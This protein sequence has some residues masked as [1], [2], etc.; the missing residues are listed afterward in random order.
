MMPREATNESH[1][2]NDSEQFSFSNQIG[3]KR[4]EGV[5]SESAHVWTS[6]SDLKKK[7]NKHLKRK[8]VGLPGG[9]VVKNLPA[10]PGSIGSSPGLGRSRM[11]QGNEAR[12][13]RS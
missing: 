11:T 10:S 4:E 13:P 2:S 6:N 12:E 3:G 8:C 1:D 7:N 5:G 9:P